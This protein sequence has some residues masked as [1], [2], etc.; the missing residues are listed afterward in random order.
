MPPASEKHQT[1]RTSSEQERRTQQA[2][3]AEVQRLRQ[4][5]AQAR[6]APP[7]AKPT[8]GLTARGGMTSS[9]MIWV[10][11]ALCGAG[12]LFALLAIL[13]HG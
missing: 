12:L 3:E 5:L 4:E 11:L 13:H 1:P 9:N 8:H 7:A 10:A 6:S 2:L